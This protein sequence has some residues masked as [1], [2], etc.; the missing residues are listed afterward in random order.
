M[1]FLYTEKDASK[2][3]D[4]RKMLKRSPTLH[5]PLAGATIKLTLY[6]FHVRVKFKL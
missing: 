1:N 5:D 4:L 2:T 6:Y 3:V